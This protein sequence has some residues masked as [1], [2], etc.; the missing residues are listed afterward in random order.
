M[1]LNKYLVCTAA[2]SMAVL[3]GCS[4]NKEAAATPAPTPVQTETPAPTVTP[5][6]DV[7]TTL[8]DGTYTKKAEAEEN[9]YTYE[10]TMVVEGGKITSIKY[11]GIDAEGKSKAQLSLDGEYVMTEDGPTW[12]AQADSLAAF[13]IENQSTAGIT[14]DDKGKTD[15]VTGVSISVNGFVEFVN[16]LIEEA[17]APAAATTLKDGTYTKKAEEAENGY[18]Y[19]MTMTVEGGKVTALTYDGLNEEGKSKAQLSLDGEYVMTEDG[20]TWSA[21]AEALAAY[22][23]E[24]QATTGITMDENGK[25]DAVAGVSISVNGFVDFA[26]AL[27]QEAAQ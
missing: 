16:A 25:T 7:A 21:Q 13:V 3:T 19:E 22:V 5:D 9:G 8:N 11:D 23:L 26:N 1:K 15:A 6:T 14:M 24:N 12:S 2:L 10:M 4:N 20:P 18:T 17:S 27:L